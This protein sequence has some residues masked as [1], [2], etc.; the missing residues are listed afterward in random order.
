[1]S[2]SLRIEELKSSNLN[3]L[4]PLYKLVYGKSLSREFLRLK[5]DSRYTGVHFLGYIAYFGVQAVAF[6][7][8]I[9][10][11]LLY[12]GQQLLGAQ[13]ADT[14]THP[15]FV[16][17]G[18]FTRLA[19]LTY[20]LAEE[21]GISLVFGWPNQASLPGFTRRLGWEFC[22]HMNAVEIKIKTFPLEYLCSKHPFILKQYS[23][24]TKQVLK[25]Y[26]SASFKGS[27]LKEGFSGLLKDQ[28][29]YTYKNRI[30]K[31]YFIRTSE[32][33]CWLKVEKGL[34]IGDLVIVNEAAGEKFIQLLKKLAFQLGCRKITFQYSPGLNS[35]M[36]FEHFGRPFETWPNGFKRLNDD[37]S[38]EK[39]KFTYGD[40]DTF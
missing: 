35:G 1:M 31:K 14:M 30:S 16:R 4:L 19:K 36:H 32:A 29:F 11:R 6:Y 34:K 3:D 12:E 8:L 21:K 33:E 17:Q 40:L 22:G 20:K 9:P 2:E 15:D 27:V 5:Y 39:F 7:G 37:F 18:L 23:R 38:Y 10:F 26:E 28:D 24:F 25:K 13:S